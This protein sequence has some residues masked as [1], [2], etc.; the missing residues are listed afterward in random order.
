MRKHEVVRRI[1]E[2]MVDENVFEETALE[3]LPRE[4]VKMTPEQTELETVRI[5]AEWN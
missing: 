5:Q 1:M 3:E 4:I 2:H